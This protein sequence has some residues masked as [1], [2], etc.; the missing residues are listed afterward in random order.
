M[1][2]VGARYNRAAGTLLGLTDEVGATR[3][4]IGAGW[5]ILPAVLTKVEYVHQKYFGYPATN[6]FH[7][8]RFNGLMLEGIVAF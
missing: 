3:W 1:L 4:Q 5:F 6:K 8:G 7:G 2:F